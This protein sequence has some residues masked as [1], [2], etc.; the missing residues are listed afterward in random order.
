MTYKT[1]PFAIILTALITAAIVFGG[2]YFWQ[3]R[4]LSEITP[5]SDFT[6]PAEVTTNN[7]KDPTDKAN[8]SDNENENSQKTTNNLTARP[9]LNDRTASDDKTLFSFD[10]G[11]YTVT[12]KADSQ[13][14][15]NC[16]PLTLNAYPRVYYPTGCVP[17]DEL[18]GS[19]PFDYF[20][21]DPDYSPGPPKEEDIIEEVGPISI[22]TDTGKT[23]TLESTTIFNIGAGNTDSP[24]ITH[25]YISNDSP[26][27][28]FYF[29]F[30]TSQ[31]FSEYNKTELYSILKTMDWE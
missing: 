6:A 29:R 7:E 21:F 15:A 18:M 3:G 2:I 19:E 9:P 11:L 25:V 28:G 26:N 12:L 24:Y 31:K 1:N 5:N 8:Q 16:N 13:K 10:T 30:I 22:K 14:W 4:S 23:L 17:K 27:S 20:W